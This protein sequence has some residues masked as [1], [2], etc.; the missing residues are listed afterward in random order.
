MDREDGVGR[1]QVDT[2]D[3]AEV[4]LSR[5][6]DDL[7]WRNIDPTAFT[8]VLWLYLSAGFDPKVP[9]R[10]IRRTGGR[11]GC[12]LALSS[13]LDASERDGKLDL[14]RRPL[15]RAPEEVLAML[16]RIARQGQGR[17]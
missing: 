15:V 1:D 9:L 7:G 6:L 17:G 3:D 10:A 13:M 11:A 8:N 2:R 16:E 12:L 4:T 14:L 5:R